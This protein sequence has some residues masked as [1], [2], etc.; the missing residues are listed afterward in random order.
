M[1]GEVKISEDDGRSGVLSRRSMQ[2]S[3]LV[4]MSRI[5][6]NANKQGREK[7]PDTCE[8]VIEKC[9]W[10]NHL[11]SAEWLSLDIGVCAAVVVSHLCEQFSSVD[12]F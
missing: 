9:W 11:Q 4:Q 5:N 6:F 1:G 8:L 7:I 12:C 3:Y 2:C 10:M